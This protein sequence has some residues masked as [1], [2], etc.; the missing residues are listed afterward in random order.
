MVRR[1]PRA[2]KLS[3]LTGL[4]L[5]A[6][7]AAQGAALP[8]APGYLITDLG[9]LG[10]GQTF[11]VAINVKGDVVGYSATPAGQIHAFLLPAGGLMKDLGTLGGAASYGTGINSRGDLAGYF[12]T[13]AGQIHAFVALDNQVMDL[14]VDGGVASH[15]VGI[16]DL[17]QVLVLYE[18]GRGSMIPSLW[19]NGQSLLFDTLGGNS[20]SGAS[21][22]N[23]GQVVGSSITADGTNHAFAYDSF[24]RRLIDLGDI[25]AQGT[26]KGTMS[27]L[28]EIGQAV[29]IR[30]NRGNRIAFGADLRKE[31]DF[32]ADKVVRRGFSGTVA[33]WI[34]NENTTAGAGE[35]PA[36]AGTQAGIWTADGQFTNLNQALLPNSGW[37]LQSADAINDAGVIVG[38]AL[39]PGGVPIAYM[40]RVPSPALP[41]E[42]ALAIATSLDPAIEAVA[43]GAAAA[44]KAAAPSPLA[45]ALTDLQQAR[46]LLTPAAGQAAVTEAGNSQA[47]HLLSSAANL[48]SVSD[49]SQFL[50]P[51]DRDGALAIIT[52]AR[53]SFP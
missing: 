30:I 19:Q 12:S 42:K 35:L 23:L 24:L 13:A 21:L 25:G 32:L 10:G 8:A 40:V 17:R 47:S 49:A 34:N 22:N 41:A 16:N 29:G 37:T 52:S 43:K 46:L 27:H 39:S 11:P 48:L 51:V 26:L 44:A 33:S 53:K 36:S 5:M 3:L 45:T 18:D 4:V 31:K 2:V 20:A 28:N 9:S 50:A 38:R 1:W 15:A 14:G 7:Q 6:G